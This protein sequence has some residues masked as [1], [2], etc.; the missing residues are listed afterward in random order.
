L[1]LWDG[2][3]SAV[4]PFAVCPYPGTHPHHTCNQWSHSLYILIPKHLHF[5]MYCLKIT[6]PFNFTMTLLPNVQKHHTI[7][8]SLS[9]EFQIRLVI[10]TVCHSG[11]PS[12]QHHSF[13]CM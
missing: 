10:S 5:F 9:L 1:S 7:L 12:C 6:L 2:L 8:K 4:V 11:H 13:Y 3:L